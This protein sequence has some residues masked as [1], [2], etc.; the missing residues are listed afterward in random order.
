LRSE[1]KYLHPSLF[2]SVFLL[3]GWWGPSA[4]QAAER[5]ASSAESRG[6]RGAGRSIAG[7][8]PRELSPGGHPGI[9][10]DAWESGGAKAA[11]W[12]DVPG[13]ASL[14]VRMLRGKQEGKD[15]R[16]V[17]IM[18]FEALPNYIVSLKTT[19]QI[20]MSGTFYSHCNQ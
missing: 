14:P 19:T 15:I 13:F 2:I 8:H 11:A 7:G 4:A 10:W 1:S 5:G 9:W 6:L 16:P 12:V 18:I 3:C 17:L 20:F